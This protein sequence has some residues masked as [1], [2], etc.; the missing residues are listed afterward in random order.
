MAIEPNAVLDRQLTADE[1]AHLEMLGV[2]WW[3]RNAWQYGNFVLEMSCSAQMP[4]AEMIVLDDLVA[5][6]R[7]LTR[8][9]WVATWPA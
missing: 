2:P 6:I 9:T 8:S 5:H 3:R 1:E 4:S 7:S